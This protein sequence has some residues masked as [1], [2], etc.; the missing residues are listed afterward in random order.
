M[1]FITRDLYDAMQCPP[2]TPE[3]DAAEARW[4]SQ[5]TAYRAQL[6][7]IRP[8]LP[9]SMQAFCD[10]S[11]HDGVIKAATQPHPETVQLEIDAS[12][13]PW[14]TIGYFQLRFTGVKDVSPMDDIVGNWWLYEEVHLH[15]DAG[16][17]YRVL[18]TDGEFRV[19]ADNVEL[20]ETSVPDSMS[21]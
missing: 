10:T 1:K 14:G 6:E 5:C 13:N 20:I 18:L 16:F 12:N 19:V 9:V 2:D 11:L 8:R 3:S 17:D 4:D 15:P 21:T 7:S